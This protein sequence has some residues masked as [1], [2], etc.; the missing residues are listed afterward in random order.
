MQYVYKFLSSLYHKW[1]FLRKKKANT[2]H[3]PCSSKKVGPYFFFGSIVL[4]KNIPIIN[5]VTAG[6]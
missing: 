3:V 1:K 2:V 5:F 4:T 6:V